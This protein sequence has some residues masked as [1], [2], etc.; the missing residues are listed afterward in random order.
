MDEKLGWLN[1]IEIED[2]LSGDAQLVYQYCGK[3]VL[4]SL[5]ENLPSMSLYI[6][7]KPL[8]EAKRRYIRQYIDGSNVKRL[9]VLLDVSESFIYKTIEADK[10]KKEV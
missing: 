9:C 5:L 8:D 6:S 4:K 1:Q 7:M 2:L 3:E 10:M